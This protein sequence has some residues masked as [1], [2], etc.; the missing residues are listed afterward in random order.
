MF[1]ESL[2][3][4]GT[5]VVYAPSFF[6]RLRI[7][8]DRI[9]PLGYTICISPTQKLRSRNEKAKPQL[10]DIYG[11][12]PLENTPFKLLF[13]FEFYMYF[14]AEPLLF[15]EAITTMKRTTWTPLGLHLWQEYTE[16]KEAMQ[17]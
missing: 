17:Q 8:K 12:R 10:V 11:Y 3:T 2:R 5:R 6:H 15:P 4:F 9:M 13:V 1:P 16:K 14:Y 7:A